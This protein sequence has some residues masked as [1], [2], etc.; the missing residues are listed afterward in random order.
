MSSH[1]LIGDGRRCRDSAFALLALAGLA[2]PFMPI[3]G[4]HPTRI[5]VHFRRP[6]M[7]KSAKFSALTDDS[8]CEVFAST[9]SFDDAAEGAFT[10]VDCGTAPRTARN[11]AP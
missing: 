8:I 2:A 11:G 10:R 4:D 9:L 6:D 5:A 1:R 7:R 3:P